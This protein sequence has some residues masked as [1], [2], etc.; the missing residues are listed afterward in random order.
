MMK[1]ST[2]FRFFSESVSL[3]VAA[4]FGFAMACA[5]E[6]L[7]VRQGACLAYAAGF[8]PL[9]LAYAAG[10]LSS[11]KSGTAF[12]AMRAASVVAAALLWAIATDSLS[13]YMAVPTLA[14]LIPAAVLC[15][16]G[17]HASDSFPQGAAVA[18]IGVF[19]LDLVLLYFEGGSTLFSVCAAANFVL[20]LVAANLKSVSDG[21]HG[22]KNRVPAGIRRN[23]LIMLLVFSAG[24]FAIAATGL[25]QRL[26]SIV[27]TV[28]YKIVAA[29]VAFI[30]HLLRNRDVP[31]DMPEPESEALTGMPDVEVGAWRYLVYAFFVALLL[32][33]LVMLTIYIVRLIRSREG[34]QRRKR[35]GNRRSFF[36]DNEEDDEIESTLKLDELFAD[37]RR[38]VTE[39]FARL[40]RKSRFSDM[41]T[42]A[43]RVRFAFLRL[44]Q[45]M[46]GNMKVESA[47]PLEL[48]RAAGGSAIGELTADYSAMRYGDIMPDT[49]S[50]ENARKA[51]DE[52]KKI[53]KM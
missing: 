12:V 45:S 44:K 51:M 22:G 30:R 2:A 18:S 43:E 36:A 19:M 31:M 4:L 14:M 26:F 9:L 37:G 52:I 50:G 21:I 3:A 33:C 16:V 5:V 6:R 23:N 48:G 7:L 40:R 28:A 15:Y 29:V 38:R 20:C 47:T 41:Q 1:R 39:F 25:V 32:F 35:D 24:A 53:R 10:R 34:R 11:G 42:D 46:A 8:A 49:G 13:R 27:V 17:V